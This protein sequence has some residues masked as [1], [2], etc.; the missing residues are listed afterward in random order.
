M[1]W[2][3][4][5]FFF[6][7]FFSLALNFGGNG[8]TTDASHSKFGRFYLSRLLLDNDVEFAN[9]GISIKWDFDS[10]SCE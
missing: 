8:S 3:W 5:F 2:V 7:S 1:C 9:I 4:I 10:I 6:H